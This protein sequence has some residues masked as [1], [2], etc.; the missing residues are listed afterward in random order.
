MSSTL[1]SVDELLDGAVGFSIP[2]TTPFRGTQVREGLLL[3]GPV[4]WAEFAPFPEYGPDESARWLASAVEAGW[5]GWPAPVRDVVPV[6]AIVPAVD[7]ETAGRLTRESGCTTVKVKVAEPGQTLDDDVARVAAVRD[8]LG[9]G[10][11]V[12]VDANGAW[13]TSEAVAALRQLAASDLEYVEQPCSTLPECAAVRLAS[14]VRVA[15]DEGVRKA[16]DP[17]HV[18]GLREAADVLVL[19]VPPLGGVRPALAVAATYGLPCVVSSALD[20]SVGLSAGLAL[21]ASLPELPYA[22]GLGS[23]RLLTADVTTRRLLPHEGNLH[24]R[25]A[26]PDPDAVSAA[27]MRPAGRRWWE[28]RLREAAASL[29]SDLSSGAT[30]CLAVDAP[31]G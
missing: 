21:A 4:G 28:A 7:P 25:H 27:S 16:A 23:G 19:K 24:V 5:I 12:R 22:C 20:T 17:T 29:A 9:A 14:G 15:V 2:L 8:A 3:K 10:G 30:R 18:V 11:C 13:T 31:G 6:N 1:P 26:A